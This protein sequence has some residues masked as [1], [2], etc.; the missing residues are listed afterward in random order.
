MFI[1]TG[2]SGIRKKIVTS[3]A[4]KDSSS[5][6]SQE[7]SSTSSSSVE[8]LESSS[9]E[10]EVQQKKKRKKKTKEAIR[11]R[12]RSKWSTQIIYWGDITIV[13]NSI[14]IWQ[15]HKHDVTPVSLSVIRL[16]SFV[17]CVITPDVVP[18][19][20]QINWVTLSVLLKKQ[21]SLS[22]FHW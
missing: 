22:P 21:V 11:S 19:H 20:C 6:S 14:T 12:S 8:S 18:I 17:N 4:K 16:L 3:T 5:S 15:F 2:P 7:P 9:V 13:R 1:F 10:E